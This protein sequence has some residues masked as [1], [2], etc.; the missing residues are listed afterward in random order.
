[1]SFIH[2]KGKSGGILFCYQRFLNF[3]SVI[4]IGEVFND[5]ISIASVV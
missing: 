1:M 4:Y 2:A 3:M 5:A